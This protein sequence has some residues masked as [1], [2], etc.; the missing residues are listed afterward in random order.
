MVGL[1]YQ[2]GQGVAKD[3]VEAVKWYSKAA[4]QGHGVAQRSLA[5]L[6][7]HLRRQGNRPPQSRQ[8]K[9]KRAF[10]PDFDAGTAAYEQKDYATALRHFRPLAKRGNSDAQFQLGIMYVVGRGV[11]KDLSEAVRWFRKAAEW[12]HANAQNRLGD[13]Y[14]WGWGVNRQRDTT[15]PTAATQN[16]RSFSTWKRRG[17]IRPKTR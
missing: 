4:E 12:G 2:N 10:T 14:R 9:A 7:K 11:S 13:M 5:R 8:I 3:Y 6:E 1:M 16:S 15:S 17:L